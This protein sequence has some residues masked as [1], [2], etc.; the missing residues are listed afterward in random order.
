MDWKTVAEKIIQDDQNKWDRSVPAR[1]LRVAENGALQC[2]GA[3]GESFSLSEI[4][5]SQLCG[6]LEIPM[7]YYRRLPERCRRSSPISIWAG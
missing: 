6:K 3:N 5:V 1:E 7:R 2:D 4:A